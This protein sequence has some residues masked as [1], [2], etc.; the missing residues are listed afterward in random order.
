MFL[1]SLNITSKNGVIRDIKFHRGLNLIVDESENQIT[2]NSVGKTT[3]LKLIDFCLGGDSKEIY[4]APETKKQEYKVVKNFLIEKEVLITLILTRDLG[5]NTDDIV[6]ERNFLS[7]KK[8]IKRINGENL[9]DDEFE[10][11][12]T[13]L[14]FPDHH[15]DKPTFRQIISH[16][17]RYKDESINNTLKTLSKYT[18]DAEYESLYLFLFGCEFNKGSKKQEVLA[19]LAQENTY[20]NRLEKKQTKTAFETAL[21]LIEN[22]IVKLNIKKSNFNLNENFEKDLEELNNTKY[23]IN[24]LSSII[25]QLNIRKDLIIE[26]R[27]ELELGK[28]T[29]DL[30]QLELIYQ[31]ATSKI[32]SINKSFND[33]VLFHNTMIEE[34]QKFIAKDLPKIEN[35]IN[36]K[37]DLL[38]SLLEKEKLITNTIAKSDSFEELEDIIAE[39][40]EKHRRKGEY[41]NIIGQLNEVETNISNFKD[42]LNKIDSELFSDDFEQNL[43]TQ[44]NKFNIHFASISN[45]LYG[46]QYAIKYDIIVNK[47]RQKLYKFSAFNANM[48][49]GKKQGE[50]SCFDLAYIMFAN[51]ENMPSLQFLLNDK[52]ELMDD[53]QLIKIAEFVN[54]NNIQFVAS[55]LNDKLPPEIN[56][57]ENFVIKLSQDDKLF[58]IENHGEN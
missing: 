44:L 28:S 22:D 50:I 27:E 14:I 31:Q 9:T 25:S 41:E 55:I 48:S 49:S 23:E 6:I 12:L 16:N 8:K 3:V 45:E 38:K 24:K 39:L 58:R 2:G 47:N 57:E 17:I 37:Y 51:E 56:K 5:I 21:S 1:K 40:T 36:E 54:R 29:I 46:E 4:V 53:K 26:A 7:W 20:K 19:K 30:K 18:S 43:K 10:I 42:Q 35:N 52:K 33:L 11:R 15:E 13:N 34:K 32:M